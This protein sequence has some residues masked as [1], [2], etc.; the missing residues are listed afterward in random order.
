[1]IFDVGSKKAVI[2]LFLQILS[3][4]SNRMGTIKSTKLLSNLMMVFIIE[5]IR[6]YL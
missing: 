5:K 1:M 6:C 3:V 2:G 4:K